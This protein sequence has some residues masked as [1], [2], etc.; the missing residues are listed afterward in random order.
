MKNLVSAVILAAALLGSA[1]LVSLAPRNTPRAPS[2]SWV[3]AQTAMN[4][5]NHEGKTVV[6]FGILYNQETGESFLIGLT[7]ATGNPQPTIIQITPPAAK[8]Q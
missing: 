7:G 4:P 1:Y 8:S 6:L 2:N 3:L 5:I